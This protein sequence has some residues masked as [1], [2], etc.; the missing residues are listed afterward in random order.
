MH[1]GILLTQGAPFLEWSLLYIAFLPSLRNSF[2]VN[3]MR[4]LARRVIPSSNPDRKWAVVYD[5]HCGFCIRTMVVINY[6]DFGR[7]VI[8]VDLE[9]EWEQINDS[10]PSLS[11]DHA[12]H[13]MHVIT[14]DSRVLGGFEG[15]RELTRALPLLWPLLP[16]TSAPFVEKLG[17]PIY[18]FVAS[19]RVR[20]GP[21]GEGHCVVP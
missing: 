12:R 3:S 2:P 10:A 6:L 11:R 14:P 15:F 16:F 7:R 21:C 1:V 8:P 17:N 13:A 5:G 4:R 19:R 20:L 18:E 9:S